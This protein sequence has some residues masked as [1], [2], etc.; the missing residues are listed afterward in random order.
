[1]HMH[2]TVA[3]KLQGLDCQREIDGDM[4]VLAILDF[5]RLLQS[6]FTFADKDQQFLLA[7]N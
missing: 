1:M 7:L 5:A 6:L 4:T 2:V 3:V